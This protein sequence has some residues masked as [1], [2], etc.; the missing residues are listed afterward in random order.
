MLKLYYTILNSPILSLSKVVLAAVNYVVY[1]YYCFCHYSILLVTENIPS[2]ASVRK[3][4]FTI[5]TVN[6]WQYNLTGNRTMVIR[7]QQLNS[8]DFFFVYLW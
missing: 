6:L 1:S 2:A 4:L 5:F 7:P 3:N 8:T